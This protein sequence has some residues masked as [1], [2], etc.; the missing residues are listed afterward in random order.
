MDNYDALVERIASA[1]SLEK[2]EIERRVEA[3]RAKLSGL[4]SKEGAAQIVASELQVSFDN[5][6]LKISE[7]VPAVTRLAHG[8]PMGAD[9]E[10][11]DQITLKMAL[12]GRRDV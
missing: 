3:K 1:S 5:V 8:L 11:A 2:A 6:D 9:I 10:F 4:I 7:I 12:A